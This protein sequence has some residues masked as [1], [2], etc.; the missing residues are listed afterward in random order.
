MNR[1]HVEAWD[2]DLVAQDFEADGSLRDI[3]LRG[4]TV[5]DWRTVLA[6]VAR[7]PH[8]ATFRRAN[9]IVAL[10]TEIEDLFGTPDLSLSFRVAGIELA[11]H[12]FARD[13]IELD[14]VP[15]GIS[16]A[17]LRGLLAFMAEIGKAT[18][19]EVIMTPENLRET[20]LFRYEPGSGVLKWIPT[21]SRD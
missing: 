15:D 17:A 5:A 20:P 21:A 12:F 7:G 9:E 8:Q 13:E 18:G 6:I 2:W 4:A 10:P 3:Y 1:A 16:P 11:C 19:K 14:F